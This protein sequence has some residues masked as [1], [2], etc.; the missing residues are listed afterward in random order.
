MLTI[1][2]EQCVFHVDCMW[3]ST[4]GEGFGSCGQGEGPKPDFFGTS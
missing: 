1:S 4:M 3:T 2:G